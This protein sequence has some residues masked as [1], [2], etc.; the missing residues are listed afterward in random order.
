MFCAHFLF[1]PIPAT[2]ETLSLYAQFLT[3]S[4][5]S[6]ESVKNY[7][8]GVKLLH[9]MTDTPCPYFGSHELRMALRGMARMKPHCPKQAAPITPQILAAILNTL[10]LQDNVEHIVMWALFVTA[11]FTLARKSN[12]VLSTNNKGKQ[13][14][15]Q[16]ILLA[17]DSMLVRFR[18]TKTIQFGQKVL[19]VPLL[20]MPQSKLCPVR[21]CQRMIKAVPARPQDSAFSL[22]RPWGIAP[23]T[24]D[25]FQQFLKSKIQ[26]IGLDASLFSSHS[27]RRGGA[28][29]AFK[30]GVRGELIQVQGD[31]L[32]DAYTRYIDFSLEERLSVAHNMSRAIAEMSL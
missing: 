28:T 7:L 31:W 13:I 4:F 19:E 11:F 21:A 22:P 17:Q 9:T 18:W 8:S 20:K 14:K 2:L 12:L 15:R 26:E 23:V 32:S 5:R 10:D 1:E 27:F 29:W 30:V 3:R 6:V 16:D 24:Y 25:H